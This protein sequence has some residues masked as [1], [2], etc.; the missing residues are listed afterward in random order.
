MKK[1]VKRWIDFASEDLLMAELALKEGINNQVCFHSQQCVEKVLKAF[2][3]SKGEI[4]PQ[5][6][7]LAD[8]LSKISESLFNDLRD[9]ILLLDRF[10]IPTRYPDALPGMLPEGLPS[11]KDAKEALNTAKKVF[12]IAKKEMEL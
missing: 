1:E 9:E 4:H 7:K 8:I 12:E 6:H 2:I 3:I 10:Y 5:S 11:E